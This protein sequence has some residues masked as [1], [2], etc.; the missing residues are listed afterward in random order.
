MQADF[1]A[2]ATTPFSFLASPTVLRGELH[3]AT[4]W[5]TGSFSLISL[6]TILEDPWGGYSSVATGS[7]AAWSWLCPPGCSGLY[8]VTIT[9]STTSPATTTDQVQA[10]LYVN[11]S[12][13]WQASV[14]WGVNGHES[15]TCGQVL[16]PLVGGVDYVQPYLFAQAASTTAPATAGQYPTCEIAW[17]ST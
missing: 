4:S 2:W 15:G 10:V 6:D 8:E 17:L 16:V 11:G 13:Y 5:A 7:Q 3:A 1:T 12:I 14:G 9:A